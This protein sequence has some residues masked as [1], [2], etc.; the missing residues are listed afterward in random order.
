M[1]EECEK[2]DRWVKRVIKG[3][4]VGRERREVALMN[5]VKK[6]SYKENIRK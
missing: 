4:A 6:I 5:L 1:E 2:Q 3:I